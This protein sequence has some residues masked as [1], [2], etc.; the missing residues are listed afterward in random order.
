MIS[1]DVDIKR[2]R[3]LLY[4]HQIRRQ[5]HSDEAVGRVVRS[6]KDD[7]S[8]AYI[9]MPTHKIFE[10]YARR[11]ENRNEPGALKEAGKERFCP[12]CEAKCSLTASS[13]HEC[14][15]EFS[16]KEEHQF[17]CFDCGHLNPVGSS[18]PVQTVVLILII[19]ILLVFKR[20]FA[21]ELSRG[22][23][24]LTKPR[25]ARKCLLQ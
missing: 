6:G 8:R 19:N 3:V 20:L 7:M 2:L 15:H 9:I 18:S 10:E 1:E 21:L 24:I 23:W 22:E 16:A 12:V 17:E 5:S 4:L 11:V 25:W 14:G 13:C